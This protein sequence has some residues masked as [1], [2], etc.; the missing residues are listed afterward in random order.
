MHLV[1]VLSE[2]VLPCGDARVC[3]FTHAG[4]VCIVEEVS[5]DS[6]LE[7]KAHGVIE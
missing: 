7:E 3:S 4:R 1:T 5:V 2:F 6:S